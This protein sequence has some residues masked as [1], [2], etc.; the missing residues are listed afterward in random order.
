MKRTAAIGINP[1]PPAVFC[2]LSRFHIET[3]EEFLVTQVEVTVANDGWVQILPLGLRYSVCGASVNRPNSCQPSAA[4]SI[5][6]DGPRILF[7][8]IELAVGVG[9]RSFA[10]RVAFTP[11]FFTRFP[12]LAQPTGPR[13]N[14]RTIDHSAR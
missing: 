14:A 7:Q 13:P 12:G 3:E 10:N 5:R 4:A 9:D 8:T 1:R 11:D 2:S 6:C